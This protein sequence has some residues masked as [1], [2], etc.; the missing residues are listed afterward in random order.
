MKQHRVA[1]PTRYQTRDYA[2]EGYPVKRAEPQDYNSKYDDKKRYRSP[3]TRPVMAEDRQRAPSVN[4]GNSGGS[5]TMMASPRDRFKD[6]KE[7]FQM[8]ERA[9]QQDLAAPR[10]P[11]KESGR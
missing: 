2:D 10:K 5:A 7:K 4:S 9:R 6:A 11:K 1:S 8:M 3:Q